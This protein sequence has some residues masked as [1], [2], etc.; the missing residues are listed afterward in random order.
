MVLGKY[1]YGL[2]S[3]PIIEINGVV[4]PTDSFDSHYHG[5]VIDKYGLVRN[6]RTSTMTISTMRMTWR[7]TITCM[8][9]D[10]TSI[11]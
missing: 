6:N 9:T 2:T 1:G 8:T 10:M 11:F 7:F 4:D 3:N 5:L